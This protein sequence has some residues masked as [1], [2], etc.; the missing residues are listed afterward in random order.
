M[1]VLQ[2]PRSKF[3]GSMKIAPFVLSIA[4]GMSVLSVTSL[5][6]TETEATPSP[7]QLK[8]KYLASI[9]ELKEAIKILERQEALYFHASSEESF[10]HKELWDETAE[11]SEAI[12]KRVKQEAFT[13][14]LSDYKADEDLIATV[15]RFTPELFE[16]GEL[17]LCYAV[18]KKLVS[19]RPNNPDLK[20][21]LARVGVLTN[22]F[23]V[24]QAYAA[25]P[26]NRETISKFST[27]EKVLFSYADELKENFA[28]EI[29][30]REKDKT[31][32]LPRVE[33]QILDKGKIVIELFEDE[34]PETVA[35]FISL[36][37][38]G[39]YDGIIFHRVIKSYLAHSGLMSMNKFEPIGYTIYD[40]NNRPDRRHHFRGSVAMWCNSQAPNS[41]GA[42]FYIMNVPAPYFTETNHT[43]FG[44]V[45]E[46]MELVDLLQETRTLNEEE[47]KEEPVMDITPETIQSIKVIRKRDHAYEPNRVEQ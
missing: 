39:I 20:R 12:Y 5:A 16:T 38:T 28:R 27:K 26:S 10:E 8:E 4:M 41:G 30:L 31:A 18:T 34:A 37:E 46:G 24:A 43:V 7:P 6:Q 25:N 17:D 44:R 9:Q 47:K 3:S 1:I 14:F 21:D 22:D 29:K 23:D 15:S 45:I 11:K 2:P 32:N 42:E 33:I 40:E 13:L 19:L 35:N 36:I